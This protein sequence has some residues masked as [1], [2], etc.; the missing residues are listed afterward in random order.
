MKWIK[1]T[2][3]LGEQMLRYAHALSLDARGEDIGVEV[4][5]D[6][7]F[8]LF[9][10]LPRLPIKRPGIA[11]LLHN[12]MLTLGRDAA[13]D[14]AWIDYGHVESLGDAAGDYFSLDTESVPAEFAE[15]SCNLCRGETVAVHV[16][17]PGK[18]SCSCTPDYYNWAISGM[19]QWIPD[20]R[21]VVITDTVGLA[22]RCLHFAESEVEW[23]SL[24]QRKH[25]Y[26]FDLMRQA[27]HCITSNT[28]ES[29]WGGWLNKN[30]DKIVVVPK[31]YGKGV[32]YSRLLP[33][34]WTIVPV[35]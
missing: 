17:Q 9:P 25:R 14:A 32:D 26:I 20:A 27:S 4:I 24:P 19:R 3:G 11:A 35:T 15:I 34:Y 7:L 13:C 10:K 5:D 30:E 29:W 23:V 31:G 2:G 12:L 21:F 8:R 28:L 18:E 1:I 16:F 33:L 6:S 22:K